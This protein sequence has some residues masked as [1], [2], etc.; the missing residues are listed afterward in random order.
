MSTCTDE[1][2]KKVGG[3]EACQLSGGGL[4][5]SCSVVFEE[6][7]VLSVITMECIRLLKHCSDLYSDSI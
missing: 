5:W 7:S 6:A 2:H 3:I 4:A 1:V